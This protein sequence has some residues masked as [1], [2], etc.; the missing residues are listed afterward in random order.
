MWRALEFSP[1]LACPAPNM[2]GLG[3]VMADR[4]ICGARRVAAGLALLLD[5]DQAWRH[6]NVINVAEHVLQS[7]QLVNEQC[8]LELVEQRRHQ[9]SLVAQL[10]QSLAHFMA[11]R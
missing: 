10:L 2:C 3:L 1:G 7:A 4:V 9:L 8:A 11:L 6:V 5:L